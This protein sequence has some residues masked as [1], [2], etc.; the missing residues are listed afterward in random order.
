MQITQEQLS[1]KARQERYVIR[2]RVG[3]DRDAARGRVF[4]ERA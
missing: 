4:G 1:A 2:R 3:Q